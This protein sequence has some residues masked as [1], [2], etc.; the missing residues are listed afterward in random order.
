MP[1]AKSELTGT[2]PRQLVN[3]YS[4]GVSVR[5]TEAHHLTYLKLGGSKWLREMVE[6][7]MPKPEK[8]KPLPSKSILTND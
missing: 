7:Y 3:G 2:K 5:W 6:Q 1:R 8:Q 4:S